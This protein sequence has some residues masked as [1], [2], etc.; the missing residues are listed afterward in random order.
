MCIR[1]SYVDGVLVGCAAHAV[2]APILGA[3]NVPLCDR[4][5]ASSRKQV[6]GWMKRLEVYS[7]LVYPQHCFPTSYSKP[8]PAIMAPCAPSQYETGA[9][10]QQP[11]PKKPS[12]RITDDDDAGPKKKKPK[13]KA[14]IEPPPPPRSLDPAQRVCASRVLAVHGEEEAFLEAV[15]APPRGRHL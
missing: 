11:P 7:G 4:P 8:K 1:D 12:R 3:G 6:V 15:R 5:K 14:S 2:H 9:P 10:V 13:K